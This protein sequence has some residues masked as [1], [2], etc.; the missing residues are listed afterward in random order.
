[1]FLIAKYN[2]VAKTA[3]P[4]KRVFLG[5]NSNNSLSKKT[6]TTITKIMA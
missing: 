4:T 2:I 3:T 6:R 5:N 1:L